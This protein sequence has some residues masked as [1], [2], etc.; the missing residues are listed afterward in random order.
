MRHR[1][2]IQTR[3]GSYNDVA[4]MGFLTELRRHF[5]R[6]RLILILRRHRPALMR[7]QAIPTCRLSARGSPSSACQATRPISIRPNSCGATSRDGNWPI[8]ARTTSARSSG[9]SARAS[10]AF[11]G[12][13]RWR[14]HFS[15]MPAFLFDRVVTVLRETQ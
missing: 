13:P 14:S 2:A 15:A 6:Q 11:A 4:L 8:S 3:P 9:R 10:G 7:R 5:R 1:R 12:R